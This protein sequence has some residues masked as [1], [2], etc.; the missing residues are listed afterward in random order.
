MRS[1]HSKGKSTVELD[2]NI[3]VR[4]EYQVEEAIY[5]EID[6][7]LPV[8]PPLCSQ[9]D[10]I[11]SSASEKC[12]AP[13]SVPASG[14]P[15]TAVP[16]T[17]IPIDERISSTQVCEWNELVVLCEFHCYAFVCSIFLDYETVKL[18]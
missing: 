10:D 16:D 12:L 7:S 2:Y 8:A 18:H 6:E 9:R 5:A 15:S 1:F 14:V 3:F 17:A 13:S 4:Q 11:M